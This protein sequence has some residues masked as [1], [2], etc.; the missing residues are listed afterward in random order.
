[1]TEK[2]LRIHLTEQRDRIFEAVINA[3]APEPRSWGDK[4]IWEQ[5]RVHFAKLILE[6]GNAT[7]ETTI[8]E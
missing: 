7:E 5:A 8:A 1:M 2:T 4:M 3:P 6:A